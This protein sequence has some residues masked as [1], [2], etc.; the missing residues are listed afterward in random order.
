MRWLSDQALS[1]HWNLFITI[2]ISGYD[3]LSRHTPLI[4]PYAMSQ[5]NI[6]H[7]IHSSNPNV[8]RDAVR[9]S[10]EQPAYDVVNH[11]LD[12]TTYPSQQVIY[13]YEESPPIYN[14]DHYDT[15]PPLPPA[16]DLIPD[17]ESPPETPL[18]EYQEYKD[19]AV[20]FRTPSF[21][22]QVPPEGRGRT[23]S[24][25]RTPSINEGSIEDGRSRVVSAGAAVARITPV[26]REPVSTDSISMVKPIA[27]T[28]VE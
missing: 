2:L 9:Y 28:D 11:E 15:A 1:C 10:F 21:N 25:D 23:P 26:L 7:N 4:T 27:Y 24:Q 19:P 3:S 8:G 17:P 22:L 14:L 5:P 16:L 13:D 12:T 18:P 20:M 6:S